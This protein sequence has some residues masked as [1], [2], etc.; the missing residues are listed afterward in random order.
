LH[1][2]KKYQHLLLFIYLFI[3]WAYEGQP[4]K[5]EQ[6]ASVYN[7]ASDITNYKVIPVG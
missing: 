6:L 2:R 4:E 7:E 1:L 5:T 3:T